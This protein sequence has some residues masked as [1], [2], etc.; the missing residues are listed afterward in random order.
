MTEYSI[1][2]LFVCSFA[3]TTNLKNYK[4]ILRILPFLMLPLLGL[5]QTN[6]KVEMPN[7][8]NTNSEKQA[9]E[10][11]RNASFNL[12][13][14]KVRWKKA[15]LEN[16]A[17]APCSAITV[18]G[19]PTGVVATVGSTSVSVS[20]VAPTNNGGRAITGYTVISNPASSPVTGT[21]S[22]I[23]VTGLTN[24]TVYTFTVIATNEL[25]NSVSS[26]ASTA[27]KAFTCGTGTIFD[28]DGNSYN[29]VLIGTQCWTKQNLK[30]TKYNDGSAIS[31][32]TSNNTAGWL[33]LSTGARTEYV[34]TVEP[35]Y[36]GIFGYLYNW[37]AATDSRKLCPTGWHVPTDAEWTSLI[38]FMVPSET[39]SAAASGT[40]SPNAGGKMK[41]KD[42]NSTLNIGLGWNP[43]NPP[44]PGTDNFDFSALSGGFRTNVPFPSIRNFA[45]FWSATANGI[46]GNAWYRDLNYNDSDVTR[47]DGNKSFGASIR[48]LK[49]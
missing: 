38:Q 26:T 19:A 48:C 24:G 44:N 11:K 8:G 28:L 13:E 10:I 41:S 47:S 46:S 17:G 35:G 7:V 2:H 45:W 4:M 49:D 39:V 1:N 21:S 15:A 43:G 18:P 6:S 37:Y 22:P 42:T 12:E 36:V 31:D 23:N 14:I 16:C 3:T 40:Q 30:V 25:G 33:G 32:Q 20:F 27:V 5:A 9:L 29:T 34:Q